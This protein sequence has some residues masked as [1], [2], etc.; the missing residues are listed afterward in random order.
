MINSLHI[1]GSRQMG[2]AER[3]LMRLVPELNSHNHRAIAVNA[4][5]KGIHD[6]QFC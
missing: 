6:R 3:F 2:G 4:P 5:K 1:I